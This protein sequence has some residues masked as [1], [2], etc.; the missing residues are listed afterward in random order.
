M[1]SEPPCRG[2]ER[3]AEGGIHLDFLAVVDPKPLNVAFFFF[4]GL[5]A[6]SGE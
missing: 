4:A 1:S 2:S 3:T 6:V 5:G